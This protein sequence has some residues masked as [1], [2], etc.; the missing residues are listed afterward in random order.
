M[1]L[2]VLALVAITLGLFFAD[3][4][5]IAAVGLGGVEL[6]NAYPIALWLIAFGS[7]LPSGGEVKVRRSKP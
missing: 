1:T 3:W 5:P 7:Y 4:A 6:W 2:G